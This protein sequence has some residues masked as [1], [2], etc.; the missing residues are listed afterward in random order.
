MFFHEKK[1]VLIIPDGAADVYRENGKS[2]FALARIKHLDFIAREGVCGL[3]QTLYED[4]PK[5]SLVAQ[6][7]MFGWDPRQYYP[8][9]RAS[10]ELLALED[11]KLNKG[12]LAFRANLVRMQ[13]NVLAS[14]NADYI[15]SEQALPLVERINRELC[16]EFPAFELYHNSDFRN[17]LVIRSAE[18]HPH[19]LRCP[20]PHESHGIEFNTRRLIAACAETGQQ[21]ALTI[22]QYLQRVATLL[23]GET[24][25]MLFPWS[26]SKVLKLP[27]FKES[28]GLQGPV[29]IIGSMDFLHGIAKAGSIDFFKVGNGRLDT[30][31]GAKGAKIVE[32]LSNGY[33]FV[34]CHV[35]APDEAGHMRDLQG[36][37][38][39][40][41]M[42]DEFI[43]RPVVNYFQRHRAQLGGVMVAPDHFTNCL[44]ETASLKRIET[45]SIHPV[46]FAL[47]NGRERDAVQ[48]YSEDD[49]LIGKYASSPVN[50]L[51]LLKILGVRARAC[52]QF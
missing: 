20:E 19:D 31:Y 45:H 9:G 15:H 34:I 17:T 33:E 35:N 22:N 28:A 8:G 50:H 39:S 6:L 18:V 41:E 26:P 49:V 3:M 1:Y 42:I 4:L 21:V 30:D 32:L 12:D 13:G 37:I 11:I 27:P 44:P 2:P 10:C 24:A 46:P 25:N 43:V 48:A 23:Q 51:E 29:A 52:Y 36:K 16:H 40:L 47:W 7:G 5:E 38:R 14:Y